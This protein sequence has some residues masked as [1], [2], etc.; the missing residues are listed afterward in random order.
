MS[1][2]LRK[3]KLLERVLFAIEESGWQ[4]LIV[5]RSHPFLLRVFKREHQGVLNLR[6]YIW[7]CTHGGK[8]R[9]EDEYRVQITG[10]VPEAQKD[11]TTLLLGWHEGYNVFVGFDIRK[12]KGQA[13]ASPSIQ[14][15]EGSLL[16]AHT[17]A[18]SAYDRANGE[19]AVCFR[20]EFIIEYAKNLGKLHGFTAKDKAEVKI[21]NE[22][23]K[24]DE[25]EIEAKI[26]NN[27]RKE[28][29]ANIKRKYREYDFRHRVLTAYGYTCAC[30]GV[31]L[32]LVEA[33]HI[34][35]VAS[36]TSTD[37]TINGVS[38]C[39]LHHKAYDQNLL[40]FDEK[41]RVEVGQ[42]AVAT[43]KKLGLVGG[44]AGFEKQLREAIILPADK[45]DYPAPAYIKESRRVR[46][47]AA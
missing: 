16:N 45:R 15:K 20:P 38:M 1:A 32:K 30:C 21:L 37:E 3:P 2:P 31:Q 42:S 12:H 39:S 4:A 6:I 19:I 17:H 27:A 22:V 7:N 10:V 13:S 29:I 34:I 28:V 47:W 36:D 11:E 8:N 43:L 18:F 33:A 9:A 40:S 23:D 26:K 46:S 14:V 24:V 25:A 41:Y 44:L 35:P 5:G